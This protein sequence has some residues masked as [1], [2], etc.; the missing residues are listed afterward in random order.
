M[1]NLH[2]KVALCLF[3]VLDT[4][5]ANKC[6]TGS[7]IDVKRFK[8]DLDL[9]AAE[10]FK[11]PTAYFKDNILNWL[12]AERQYTSQFFCRGQSSNFLTQVFASTHKKQ[13]QFRYNQSD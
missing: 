11:E 7:A 1:K 3:I 9:P 4:S 13:V 10:R 5:S 2:L 8:I 12:T 6:Q